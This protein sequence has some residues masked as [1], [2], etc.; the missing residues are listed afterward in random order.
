MTK[1]EPIVKQ[2]RDRLSDARNK[3]ASEVI[4]A[5]ARQRLANW[6]S[7]IAEVKA[8]LETEGETDAR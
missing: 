3:A 1:L 8:L 7:L 5:F 4:T 2:I 6:H